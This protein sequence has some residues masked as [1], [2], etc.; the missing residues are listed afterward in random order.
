MRDQ[1]K[2]RALAL[3]DKTALAVYRVTRGF[4]KD[5]VYGLSA[6]MRRAA[7]SVPSSIVEGCARSTK[8]EYCRFLDIAFGSLRELICRF[9]L[10]TR[11]DYIQ[12]PTTTET[13]ALLS[14]T[15][16]VLGSLIRSLRRTT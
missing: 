3:A 7:V 2:L 14:E 15:E 12:P 10:A 13:D 8:Q 9:S 1:K 4:P 5:E 6:Q 11:L 16:R